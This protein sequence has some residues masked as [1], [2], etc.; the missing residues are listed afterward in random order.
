MLYNKQHQALKAY[1]KKTVE[2][3][4]TKEKKYEL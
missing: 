2:L 3:N 1:Q 4:M